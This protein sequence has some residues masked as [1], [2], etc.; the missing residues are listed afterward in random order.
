MFLFFCLMA[1]AV[2]LVAA[3]PILERIGNALGV[4]R[5]RHATN[6]RELVYAV[7]DDAEVDPEEAAQIL[8]DAKKSEADLQAAVDLLNRRRELR[9]QLDDVGDAEE[10]LAAVTKKIDAENERLSVIMGEFEVRLSALRIDRNA[11]MQRI[12]AA[13]SARSALLESAGADMQ[14][15]FADQ[16]RRFDIVARR[17]SELSNELRNVEEVHSK[18]VQ[19]EVYN[20]AGQG[21]FSDAD[22][23]TKFLH[24]AYADLS[25]KRQSPRLV[26]LM[27]EAE[28]LNNQ[29]TALNAEYDQLVAESLEP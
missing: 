10:Q 12:D 25:V 11:A 6:Y 29:I 21:T 5:S 15:K 4:L 20:L 22:A 17:Q 24:D 28:G 2:G 27:E 19:A 13:A 1:M 16:R 23:R 7:A 9:R 14:A 3:V 8:H 26:Q 18:N